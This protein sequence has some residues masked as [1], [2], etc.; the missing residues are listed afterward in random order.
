MVG[1]TVDPGAGH[2]DHL[3]AATATAASEHAV[4]PV[5]LA[6]GRSP[7]DPATRR[8]PGGAE[9]DGVKRDG[10]LHQHSQPRTPHGLR[11]APG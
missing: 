8:L 11:N 1:G 5:R 4:D 9:Q 6:A 10:A 2:H 3:V 7:T